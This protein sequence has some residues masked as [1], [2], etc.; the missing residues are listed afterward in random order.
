MILNAVTVKERVSFVE[1]LETAPTRIGLIFNFLS[2]LELLAIGMLSIQVGEGYN[3][4]WVM[5]HEE[6]EVKA[7]PTE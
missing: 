3:N 5:K 1:L 6:Q 7:E 2:V 4:F